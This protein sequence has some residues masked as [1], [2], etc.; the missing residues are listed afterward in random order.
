LRAAELVSVA[1]GRGDD[2]SAAVVGAQSQ[3]MPA[4]VIGM[5]GK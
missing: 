3:P 5:T 4:V 1:C 2:V